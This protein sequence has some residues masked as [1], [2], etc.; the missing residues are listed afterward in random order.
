MLDFVDVMTEHS[1]TSPDYHVHDSYGD[2]LGRIILYEWT[3]EWLFQTPH[4][5]SVVLTYEEVREINSFMQH[6][7]NHSMGS[8]VEECQK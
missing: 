1:T 5:N 8:K 7:S 6:L 3:G 2:Y 4:G